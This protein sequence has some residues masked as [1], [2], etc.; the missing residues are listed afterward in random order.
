MDSRAADGA[1]ESPDPG[2]A[3][4]DRYVGIQFADGEVYVYDVEQPSAWIR[5]DA[6]VPV[7]AAV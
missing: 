5:S 7:A 1:N 2:T 6:A 3:E 4:F